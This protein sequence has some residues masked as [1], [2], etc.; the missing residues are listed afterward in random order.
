MLG[1]DVIWSRA[2]GLDCSDITKPCLEDDALVD[3]FVLRE[4]VNCLQLAS[5]RALLA[6][7]ISL[8]AFNLF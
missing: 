3:Q 6:I 4:H 1:C 8:N 7:E 2:L 5:W